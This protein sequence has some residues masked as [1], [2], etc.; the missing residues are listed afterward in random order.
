M[1]A[2]ELLEKELKKLNIDLDKAKKRPGVT[3]RELDNTEEKI[4]LKT[5]ILTILKGEEK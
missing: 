1:T 4:R 3:Q 2:I 5:E